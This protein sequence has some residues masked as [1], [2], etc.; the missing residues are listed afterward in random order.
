MN[1]V[2]NLK[3]NF[4][5]NCVIFQ[6]KAVNGDCMIHLMLVAY[7]ISDRQDRRGFLVQKL[8]LYLIG[9]RFTATAT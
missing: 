6:G 7:D 2:P 9:Q 5:G 4:F 8:S 3:S 1:L